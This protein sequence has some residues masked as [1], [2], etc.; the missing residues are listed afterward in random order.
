MLLAPCVGHSVCA[1]PVSATQTYW[2][3]LAAVIRL[4]PC[5]HAVIQH[6]RAS[7]ML[8]TSLPFSDFPLCERLDLTLYIQMSFLSYGFVFC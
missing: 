8:T 6:L 3:T 2:N 5:R 4:N 7:I 1:F